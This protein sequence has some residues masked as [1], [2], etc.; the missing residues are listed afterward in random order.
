L[1]NLK[2]GTRLALS[3]GAIVLLLVVIA[4][5]SIY[6]LKSGGDMIN[7]IVNNRY[8]KVSLI[9]KIKQGV[10]VAGRSLRD[11]ALATKDDDF[12]AAFAN[13]DA[14]LSNNQGRLKK[15]ETLLDTPEGKDAF[16]KIVD[17]RSRYHE[18]EDQEIKLL[19]AEDKSNAVDLMFRELA[20]VQKDYLDAL[21][22]FDDLQTA[23][24]DSGGKE[25]LEQA[26]FASVM[27]AV[28]SVLAT[29]LAAAIAFLI[30]RSITRPLRDAVSVAQTVATG[31]L[32]S[33]FEIK[34]KDESAQLL[35]ALKAMNDNLQN[36]VGEVRLGTESI[37]T[38]SSQIV[39]GNLNLSSRTEEQASS[40]EETAA[41][42]E[43]MTSTVKQNSDNA[44]QANG[45]AVSASNVATEGGMVV[46]QVVQTMNSIKES[47][48]K[49]VDII[50]VIDSIAFQTNILALN[51]AVEAARAGEQGRGFAVV[52]S[53]VRNLAQR[54]A[55]AAKEIKSLIGDS[56]EKVESGGRLVDQAGSTMKKIV[57]SVQ[58]VT[59]IMSE[60][61]SASEE[62]TTGIEQINQA[63]MQM[64]D[65]TQQN[66]ALVEE[67]AAAASSLEDQSGKLIQAVSMFKLNGDRVAVVASPSAAIRQAGSVT[68]ITG[69]IRDMRAIN[70]GLRHQE[71][72]PQK[73]AAG[74]GDWEQF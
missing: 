23:L 69:K 11:A 57:E 53:E 41:S 24:M 28:L 67:A 33:K 37:A 5:L 18:V 27:V 2:I 51:A 25:A 50:G 62:Q 32:S 45:L 16:K 29:V 58:R 46:S 3:F 59:D 54:S 40:L 17:A 56:V 44:R 20:P 49:I 26:Q 30:T 9:Y 70:S 35:A 8:A 63:I 6:R 19:K 34:G 61:A 52:A 74:G 31:D 14:A 22:G 4:G 21:N 15:L 47:A 39:T 48:G 43:E 36:I 13:Y 71:N 60:I 55:A 68:R 10:N 64:D 12:K 42:M 38:A 65:V 72:R 66:A 7:D 73:I 1:N